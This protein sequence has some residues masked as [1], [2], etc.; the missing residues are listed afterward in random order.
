[1]PFFD[2]LIP[3]NYFCDV[4]FT[5]LD[6]LPVLG[7]EIYARKLDIVPGGGAYNTVVA[8]QRLNVYA[9]WAG[10]LG[11][12][13]FS[14]FVAQALIA[15]GVDMALVKRLDRPL[16]RITVALSYPTDRAF[17]THT[18][19]SLSSTDLAIE[20]LEHVQCRHLHFTGLAVDPRMP[21]LIDS[22]HARGIQVSMDCQHRHDTLSAPLIRE[23]ISR[24]DL[25]MP[26]ATE[27]LRLTETSTLND[28]IRVLR[29]LIACG[30]IKN[31]GQ[32]AVGWCGEKA[33]TS[34][35]I[36]V[37]VVDTTGAG[38]VFNAGFLAAY[39]EGWRFEECLRCGNFCGGM[40][41]QGIG[42]T[43]TAPSRN[44]LDAWLE[45]GSNSRL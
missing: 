37:V 7:S 28:A 17:V 11:T 34:A 16:R 1:M 21:T 9:G 24:L 19:E 18:D 13:V 45:R 41:V 12:D 31:G 35:A 22:C 23:I 43:S 33:F 2:I 39:L 44:Q 26:N 4:V 6:A 36:E 29:N 5:G 3:G 10:V 15:E 25:F 30:L 8:L 42:G 32:G 27:A 14:Q 38:D 40:S 20:A